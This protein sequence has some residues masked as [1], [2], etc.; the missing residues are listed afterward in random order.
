M[1]K[2]RG[3]EK[4]GRKAEEEERDEEIRWGGGWGDRKKGSKKQVERGKGA[5]IINTFP[6]SSIGYRCLQS[7][8]WTS[9]LD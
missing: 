1:Q 4:G 3:R 7:L 5:G 6:S 8:D 2:E 9:G